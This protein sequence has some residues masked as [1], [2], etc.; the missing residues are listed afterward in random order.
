[1]GADP[2]LIKAIR[3]RAAEIIAGAKAYDVPALCERLGLEAG[4][5]DEAMR[6]KFKYA[7][8]RLME[9]PA[10]KLLPMIHALLA[11]E[12]DFALS[13][14]LAKAGEADGPRVSALTRRR[15]ISLFDGQYLCSEYDELTFLET[16]WPLGAMPSVFQNDWGERGSLREDVLQHTV[17]NDDWSNRELLEHLGLIDCSKALFFR[18]LEALV[19]PTAVPDTV[20]QAR[21]EGINEHLRHDGYRLQRAG[22]LSGSVIYKV[23]AAAISSPAEATISGTLARFEPEQVHARWEAALD[24]RATDPA[25]AITLARTLLEDV[26]RWLLDDLAPTL[27]APATDQDDLP[28]L[29][30]KLS[31]ALNLAPDGHSEPVFKQILGNCQSIVESLGALR[32]RLGDAHSSGPRKAKPAPRHAEL[33]VNLAGSMATFLVATWEARKDAVP[34]NEAAADRAA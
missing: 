7:H 25:G 21:V 22:R 14:L 23:E 33:A 26:F 6:S 28:Q 20:Q 11:E 29:Y 1:M 17:R 9:V 31:K 15:I 27:E 3:T 12:V 18:V 5:E 19:H 34:A 4:T 16:I 8:S 24:R 30:R 10:P 13:E 2:S 32:N